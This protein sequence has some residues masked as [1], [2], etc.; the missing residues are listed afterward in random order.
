VN[1]G[2]AYS[3]KGQ[4]DQAVADFNK[5]L[6]I[7]PK[8]ASAYYNRGMA[9]G[10]KN[11]LDQTIADFNKAVE[12]NPS[13]GRAYNN[14]AIIYYLKKEYDKAWNDAHKVEGLGF[15]MDPGFLRKLREDSG[16]EK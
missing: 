9:Y 13:Y 3:G 10:E 15:K 8:D 2:I 14:R 6:E 16:R 5:A 4:H 11:Q 1:R 7:N 12:I